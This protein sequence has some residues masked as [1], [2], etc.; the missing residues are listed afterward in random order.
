VQESI[1]VVFAKG[2]KTIENTLWDCCRS[3]SSNVDYV[4]EENLIADEESERVK[5]RVNTSEILV[6]LL[7]SGK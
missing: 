6:F 2:Y 1:K 7:L 5:G 4:T 3:A